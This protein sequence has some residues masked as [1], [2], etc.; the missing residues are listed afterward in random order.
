MPLSIAKEVAVPLTKVS[1]ARTQEQRIMFFATA[2]STALRKAVFR[3][4]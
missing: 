3:V 1:R 2:I 4:K